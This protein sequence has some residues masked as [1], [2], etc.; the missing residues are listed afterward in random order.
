MNKKSIV[1]N[2]EKNIV[3]Y[4]KNLK[5]KEFLILA[6]NS[7][8]IIQ[9]KLAFTEANFLHLTGLK[10]Q[11]NADDFYKAVK[12]HQLNEKDFECK[13]NDDLMKKKLDALPYLGEI[14]RCAKTIGNYNNAGFELTTDKILGNTFV[15]VGFIFV[16]KN[17]EYL[18]PN[19]LLQE[20]SRKLT[21]K[22]FMPI[23]ATISKNR[24]D[25]LFNTVTYKS[26]NINTDKLHFPKNIR[27]MLTDEAYY[28]IKPSASESEV[29]VAA[30]NTHPS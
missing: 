11:I 4:D 21:Q 23:V 20:D 14:H 7:N 24:N 18:R 5:G 28:T 8:N 9:F 16:G 29:A 15:S 13:Y 12:N 3:L 19:S 2:I 17:G 25:K 27:A 6:K 26:K 22:P 1:K 30:E 10:T